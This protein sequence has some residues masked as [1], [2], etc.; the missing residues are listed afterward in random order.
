MIEMKVKQFENHEKNFT[1]FFARIFIGT[2]FALGGL[3]LS[4]S[5]VFAS[6]MATAFNTTPIAISTE[7][8][9]LTQSSVGASGGISSNIT[10]M[11]PGDTVNRY[12]DL[13]NS[14]TMSGQ[15]LTLAVSDDQTSALT[16]N[17]TA[18]LHVQ[19]VQCSVAWTQASSICGGTTSTVL[20]NTSLSALSSATALSVSS[21]DASSTNHLKLVISLPAGSEV[22]VNGVLPAGT[23]QG[24]S[25]GLTWTFAESQRTATSTNS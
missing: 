12:V 17:A 21:L 18:G 3:A 13:A 20:A 4:T 2:S 7:T 15:S 14:G 6:L 22:T 11:A 1:R 10:N 9:M 8:L 25:A 24:K 19:I 23:V 5:S 16:T